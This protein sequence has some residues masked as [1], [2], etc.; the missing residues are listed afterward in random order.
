MKGMGKNGYAGARKATPLAILALAAYAG[1]AASAPAI[2]AGTAAAP[3]TNVRIAQET[4]QPRDFDIAAQPLSDALTQF[5][6]ATGIQ[7][8]AHGDIVRKLSSPGVQGT[9]TPEDALKRLL[10]GTGITWRFTGD[11]TVVL[12]QPG[13][14]DAMALDPITVEGKGGVSPGALPPAYAGGQVAR[15][16]RAGLLGNQDVF[17]T[18]FNV[19]GYTSGLIEDQ[20]ARTI[21]D[22]VRNDPSAYLVN[23]ESGTSQTIAIRG[24]NTGGNNA[25]LYD[26]L[27]GLAHGRISNIESVDRVEVFK[28]ANSLLT[29]A[30]GSVGGTINLVPK[31]PLETSLTRVTGIYEAISNFGGAVDLSRRFGDDEQLGVRFNGIYR[32]G[33]SVPENYDER[34]GAASLSADF[35]VDRFRSSVVLDY[36]DENSRASNQLFILGG[37][38]PAAPDTSAA[39]Q[40]PWE[41]N[42]QDFFRGLIDM[43]ADL[44][45]GMT[46]YG[47]YGASYFEEFWLRTIGLSLAENGDFNQLAQQRRSDEFNQSGRV[48]V[49]SQ[50]ET[51]PISH[52]VSLEWTKHAR[53][54]GSIGANL[55]GYSVTSNIYDPT[56]VPKPAFTKISSDLPRTFETSSSSFAI[57]DILGA[58][59]DRILLTVGVRR[60]R[61]QSENFSATTGQQ[62]SDYDESALTPAVGLVVKPV[63]SLSLYGNFI[64]SLEQGPT[65]PS[66]AA[67]ADEV[68]PPSKTR[69]IEFGA[70]Y[71]F[72]NLGLT[73]GVFQIEK[74][75][76]ITNA[77]NVF[78]VD[79]E[80]RN[81]GA[82]L[83]AFGEVLTGL[84][85]LG[86]LTYIDSELT[87]TQGGAFDGNHGVGVPKLAAVTSVEWDTPMVRGLTLSFRANHVSSQFVNDDNT[88]K[89]PSYQLYSLGAR[90]RHRIGE[91]WLTL[92]ANVDNIL[93]TDY[94]ITF[95]GVSNFL[96]YGAPRTISLSATME[97]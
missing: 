40:Q 7:V 8:S 51:G 41:Y 68:F 25:P 89:I 5:G 13:G 90:Y 83:N 62:T 27:P 94:W 53:R 61:V 47:A 80:Q 55:P 34:F 36:S 96:Y 75:N 45:D 50:L 4:G 3:E 54:G 81:R 44:F 91:N 70:K 73:A 66:S 85:V 97:F 37:S 24:F 56:F 71:D 48:G 88:G 65:A 20:H 58:F 64:E 31:R 18:P 57:A 19:T 42:D 15:G 49:R 87:K 93:N 11:R 60:Q 29:G 30:V 38:V 1:M 46:L 2:A 95:P 77:S 23:A 76:G 67:N 84:R 69:Q 22:I 26:G 92:R 16:A 32:D 39:V 63:S 33:E 72:G 74:P 10:A 35:R 6:Q 12:E 21:G 79:G 59:D 28:G 9:M 78:S 17:D 43:E 52:S 14:K 82:E 86:G